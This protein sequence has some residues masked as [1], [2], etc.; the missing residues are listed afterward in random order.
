MPHI[1]GLL[2]SDRP[3]FGRLTREGIETTTPVFSTL[4]RS[5][6]I[7]VRKVIAWLRD[8]AE[9]I[10]D[11]VIALKY[12]LADHGFDD[13]YRCMRR[14]YSRY[15]D[16]GVLASM[17]PLA[18][19]PTPFAEGVPRIGQQKLSSLFD[20]LVGAN[21][22]AAAV[23]VETWLNV[24]HNGRIILANCDDARALIALLRTSGVEGDQLIICHTSDAVDSA[25]DLISEVRVA[26]SA[27]R[28]LVR[29]RDP[30]VRRL[31]M[32]EAKDW[33]LRAES[34]QF[35]LQ[36]PDLRE[37]EDDRDCVLTGEVRA[38]TTNVMAL[39]RAAVGSMD[40]A[41]TTRIRRGSIALKRP[42]DESMK[43]IGEYFSAPPQCGDIVSVTVRLH[44]GRLTGEVCGA[45]LSS[46]DA[47]ARDLEPTPQSSGAIPSAHGKLHRVTRSGC[48]ATPSEAGFPAPSML[49]HGQSTVES[50]AYHCPSATRVRAS[51]SL[52]SK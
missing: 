41:A 14:W 44:R 12:D 1:A 32:R 9:G 24:Q 43:R 30:L 19:P 35:Q 4:D 33:V 2:R 25:S 10:D 38:M 5:S 29:E 47:M 37:T 36:F 15:G 16:R 13:A 34:H 40:A 42:S 8:R 7:T 51:D 39:A 18:K 23:A 27:E 52:S 17:L 50:A 21:R 45:T 48:S 6:T 31:V 49:V 11:Q 28:P 22:R 3:E 26:E 46:R 20:Y